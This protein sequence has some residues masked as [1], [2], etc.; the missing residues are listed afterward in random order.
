VSELLS[1]LNP[2]QKLAVQT[3]E[4]PVQINA[5]AGSGKTT[6]LVNRIAYMLEQGIKPNEIL[7]TTFTKK[8]SEE[9]TERLSKLIPK[10]SLKQITIGTSHSIGYRILSKEYRA[11]NH[12]LASAFKGNNLLIGGKHK[13]FME[14]IKE[15]IIRDRTVQFPVKE[16]LRDIPTPVFMKAISSAKNEGID[17]YDFLQTHTG[18][19]DYWEAMCEM[20]SRYENTKWAQRIIDADDLL[21]LLL[22]MFKEYPIILNKYRKFY[23]YLLVDET[24]DNNQSQYELVRLLAY[25]ENNVFVVG[26]DDQ[27]MYSFRGARPD[28]FIH[29]NQAYP[30]VKTINLEDNYRSNPGILT[31]ANQLIAN[32]TERILKTL[33][34]NKKA[35]DES[36]FCTTYKDEIDEARGVTEEVKSLMEDGVRAKQMAVLYRTNA[37]S[38]A[39]EDELIVS[40]IPYVIHG[41]VSFYDRKEIKD[42]LSYLKLASDPHDNRAFT[43]VINTPSRYLGKV[44]LEKVR[45]YNGSHYEAIQGNINLKPHEVRGIEDFM[46]LIEELRAM[47]ETATPEEMIDYL[48]DNCYKQYLID[49]GEDEDE[50]SSRLDNIATLK[51]A[52]GRYEKLDDFLAYIELM[53]SKAKHSIDGVQLMTIHK[54]K[55]LEF[56]VAFVVGMSNGLLPH[57]KALEAYE[58]GKELAIEEERR[59]AYVAITRAETL[60]FT[61]SPTT[62]NGRPGGISPFMKELNLEIEH[63]SFNEDEVASDAEQNVDMEDMYKEGL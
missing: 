52:V 48:M 24:Q 20:Y 55:G 23:K 6:V 35:D 34:A 9:M 45:S 5:V 40:G 3:I 32:N 16:Q 10:M 60:C 42:I 21:F 54:S 18:Q 12:H 44:F 28:Q 58:N 46:N 13:I 19:G 41:G 15:E 25:P 14:K 36:I 38:R 47:R 31:A 30:K 61:S 27:S 11:M 53:T 63:R 22:K 26:D 43:R 33:K 7:C 57:Y 62:F 59:L 2:S 37:Q 51:Y 17:H 50:G 4:G 56:P 1:K 39:F 8:A 29:F 49:D